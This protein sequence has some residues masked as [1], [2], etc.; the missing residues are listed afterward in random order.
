MD[1][2]DLKDQ[3][4]AAGYTDV[5][6]S[7]LKDFANYLG[8]HDGVEITPQTPP[9]IKKSKKRHHHKNNSTSKISKKST[10]DPETEV[11][12]YS[13]K[14]SELQKK[15]ISLDL[16]LQA[17]ADTV[18]V[19]S[20]R[21]RKKDPLYL[22][23]FEDYCDPYAPLDKFKPGA[24]FIR[25]P[26]HV[27]I[28]RR[29]PILKSDVCYPPPDFVAQ[30]RASERKPTPYVPGNAQRQDDLRWRLRERFTYSHPDYHT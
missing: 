4:G 11:S 19:D 25:P 7:E 8:Q 22:F 28:R 2:E 29:F 3:L 20:P 9:Q 27:G 14:I 16:Q 5:S 24:G 12:N 6:P 21:K 10:A 1:I 23:D 13:N 17:C 18:S 30:L 26:P 15:A